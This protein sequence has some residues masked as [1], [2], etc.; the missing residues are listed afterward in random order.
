MT[1]HDDHA[2]SGVGT[3]QL[4]TT[5]LSIVETSIAYQTNQ[6]QLQNALKIIPD[7]Q[8]ICLEFAYFDGMTQQ[9]IAKHLDLPLGTIKTRLRIGLSKLEYILRAVGYVGI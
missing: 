6:Q 3:A 7:E 2:I 9:E 5:Q 4:Q 1:P 8:R